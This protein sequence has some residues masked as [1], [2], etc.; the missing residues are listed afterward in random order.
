M[1]LL[2]IIFSR[3]CPISF[4]ACPFLFKFKT[5]WYPLSS[6]DIVNLGKKSKMA[7]ILTVDYFFS[8]QSGN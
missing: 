7:G 2:G 4:Y 5:I 3:T 1:L 8:G 6:P